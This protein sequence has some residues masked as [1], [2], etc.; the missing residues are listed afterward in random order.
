MLAVDESLTF[1]FHRLHGKSVN[2]LSVALL[3][4]ANEP[5]LA[6]VPSFRFH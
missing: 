2:T 4:L 1:R 5:L 3:L 6:L